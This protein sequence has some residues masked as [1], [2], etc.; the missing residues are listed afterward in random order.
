MYSTIYSVIL[1]TERLNK[2]VFCSFLMPVERMEEHCIGVDTPGTWATQA[3]VYGM[4]LWTKIKFS[5]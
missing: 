3:E 1:R 4:P 2:D 5:V